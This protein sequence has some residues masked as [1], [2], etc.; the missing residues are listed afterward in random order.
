MMKMRE[1]FEKIKELAG[2]KAFIAEFS[3]KSFDGTRCGL[4]IAD[5]GWFHADTWEN[6][7]SLLMGKEVSAPPDE[8]E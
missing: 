2:D 7:L 5:T 1:A 6:A 4:Y 3:M 8:E